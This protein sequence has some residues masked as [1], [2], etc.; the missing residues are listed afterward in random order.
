MKAV[1]LRLMMTAK[2][3]LLRLGWVI[4]AKV[5]R[6]SLRKLA[7]REIKVKGRN[8]RWARNKDW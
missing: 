3:R 5:E 6:D 2:R 1:R 8:L 4:K 7:K